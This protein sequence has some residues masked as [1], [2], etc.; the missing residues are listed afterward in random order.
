MKKLSKSW[1][2]QKKQELKKSILQQGQADKELVIVGKLYRT[3]GVK[4]DLRFEIFPPALEIPEKFYIKDQKEGFTPVTVESVSEKKGLI[5]FKEFDT[6]EKAKKITNKYLYLEKE[7]LPELEEDEY[8]VYQLIGL[9]VYIDSKKIGSIIKV[10]DRLPDVLL[11][12]RDSEGKIRHL[13]F[14]KEFVKEVDLENGRI[15]ITPPE[16]WLEL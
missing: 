8:Y 9:D 5:R 10:D 2:L 12:I 16:G 13:P 4:G 14:I 11:I 15:I 1:M 7:K 3:F 6:R